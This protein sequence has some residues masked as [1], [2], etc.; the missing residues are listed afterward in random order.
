MT[1]NHLGRH[2]YERD[3]MLEQMDAGE[4]RHIYHNYGYDQFYM[5]PRNREIA[6]QWLDDEMEE[7]EKEREERKTWKKLKA[8][9]GHKHRGRNED[10]YGEVDVYFDRKR[11]DEGEV[12]Y[13]SCCTKDGRGVKHVTLKLD[14]REKRKLERKLRRPG[15]TREE[16][17][18]TLRPALK[19]L[20]AK[21]DC[22]KRRVV[23]D[24]VHLRR[25]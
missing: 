22:G 11:H 15:I 2:Q 20:S 4:G 6:D 17:M 21:E 5:D 25:V 14:K 18:R 1:Q 12:C 19:K 23:A 13:G 3:A 24:Q 8:K 7:E 10:H 16:A 9:Y